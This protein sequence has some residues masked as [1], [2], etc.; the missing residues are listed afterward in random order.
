MS[1]ECVQKDTLSSVF[2][3]FTQEIALRRFGPRIFNPRDADELIFSGI[4][5]P[6]PNCVPPRFPIAFRKVSSRFPS[7]LLES[8]VR[9][10]NI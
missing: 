2:P 7:G 4:G 3:R 6:L 9:R 1:S 8:F 5:A 10:A